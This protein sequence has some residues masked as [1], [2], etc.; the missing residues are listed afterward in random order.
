MI[1]PF[2][3]RSIHIAYCLFEVMC[4]TDDVFILNDI[5]M[6]VQLVYSISKSMSLLVCTRNL[7]Y[8]ADMESKIFEEKSTK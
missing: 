8:F 1:V 5:S 4:V 7:H 6:F 2:F 3:G